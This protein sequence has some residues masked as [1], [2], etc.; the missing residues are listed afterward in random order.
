MPG[1]ELI[2]SWRY[3]HFLTIFILTKLER[4]WNLNMVDESGSDKP[5]TQGRN[6]LS[7]FQIQNM[8]NS[9]QLAVRLSMG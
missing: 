8:S 4:T 5:E 7:G 3:T 2:I 6:T 9:V 1:V